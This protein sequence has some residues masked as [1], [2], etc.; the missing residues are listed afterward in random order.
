MQMKFKF[1]LA[2]LFAA[3]FSQQPMQAQGNVECASEITGGDCVNTVFTAIPFLRINPDTRTG[4]MGDVG[5]AISPDA[6]A[7]YHNASKLAFINKKGGVGITYTPWLRKIVPDMFIGYLNGYYKIDDLSAL[8]GSL[9]YFN[10]GNIQF[11][12]ASGNETGQSNPNE[13]AFDVAYARKL[14]DKIG[15]G[16]TMKY[17]NSNLAKGQ[18][19]EQTT[20]GAAQAVAAD[21]SGYYNTD[22]AVKSFNS[23]LGIGFALSNIGNKV[24]YIQ[25]DTTVVK[26][27]LPINLGIG[28]AYDFKFDDYNSLMFA[29]DVNKLMVPTPVDTDENGNNIPDHRD[30]PLLTGMFSSF[31]DA[32]GGF[33]E[34]MRE[35]M[36]SLGLEYWYNDL[37]AFRAGY[38]HEHATKGNRKYLTMGFGIKYNVFGLN[39]SYLVPVNGVANHPLENTL[40]FTL[41]FDFEND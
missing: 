41:L 31:G 7:L 30:A 14:S 29:V 39:F 40:R 18:V 3:I 21:I 25:N 37:F 27:F 32:P 33:N 16:L 4:S 13:F 12:D 22:I 5:L 36:I 11:T 8:G 9:R 10:M 23:N 19:V 2:V 6:G 35:L 28:A 34:E 24:S 15:L 17:V 20:I 38:F 1:F 26:D